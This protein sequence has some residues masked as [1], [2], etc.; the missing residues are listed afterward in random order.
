MRNTS[1]THKWTY[2]YFFIPFMPSNNKKIIRIIQKHF[3]NFQ[4][5][6]KF[7]TAHITNG[8][9]ISILGLILC[10]ISLF[11]T[12]IYS[13][14]SIVSSGSTQ[15]KSVSSFGA[16]V[17]YTWFF[18]FILLTFIAFS[19]FSIRKKEKFHSFSLIHIYDFAAWF[20]GSIIIII[21]CIQSLFYMRGLQ[22]FSSDVMYWKWVILCITWA[23]VVL[24]GSLMLKNEYRKN[25]KWSFMS[26]LK[27]SENLR[28][29]ESSKDNMKLPF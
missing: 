1:F 12:W 21:L 19:I 9:K 28:S 18:L 5:Q 3:S 8:W 22:T 26:E 14:V 27:N 11:L 10:Y 13:N 15:I 16:L 29:T 20:Y 7:K 25:I 4:E 6:L 24:M 17:G 2:I 23:I